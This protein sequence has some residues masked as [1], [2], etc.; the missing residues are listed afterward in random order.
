[1]TAPTRPGAPRSRS[2]GGP[3]TPPRGTRRAPAPATATGAVQ[4]GGTPPSAAATLTW[5]AAVLIV[6]LLLSLSVMLPSLRAYI[7]QE[8][9]LAQLRADVAAVQGDIDDLDAELAR[10]KDDAYVIAQA[11]E[12]LTYVFPGE[13]PYRVVDPEFVTS[14]DPVTGEPVAPEVGPADPWF[15]TLWGTMAP[16]EDAP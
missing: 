12:R 2:R 4:R 9:Q 5:K 13:R 7:R 1:M 14:V 3:R 10:W 16:A 15:A 8:Q 11:R 6:V